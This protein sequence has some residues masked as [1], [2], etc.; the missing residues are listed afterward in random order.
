VGWQWKG[1]VRWLGTLEVWRQ[2]R[3]MRRLVCVASNRRM[4][5]RFHIIGTFGWL[6]C[7]ASHGGVIRWLDVVG[8]AGRFGAL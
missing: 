8:R 3:R 6:V 7:V 5:G 1:R 4:V 2:G